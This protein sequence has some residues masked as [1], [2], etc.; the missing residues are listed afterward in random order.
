[1]DAAVLNDS[2]S[3]KALPRTVVSDS[4]ESSDEPIT[5]ESFSRFLKVFEMCKPA[6][7]ET[8]TSSVGGK[9]GDATTSKALN[10]R[11]TGSRIL[12]QNYSNDIISNDSNDSENSE[13]SSL[14]RPYSMGQETRVDPPTQKAAFSSSGS[15]IDPSKSNDS[16]SFVGAS[17]NRTLLPAE[18]ASKTAR[19][20]SRRDSGS[21]IVDSTDKYF[22]YMG[23]VKRQVVDS[24]HLTEALQAVKQEFHLQNPGYFADGDSDSSDGEYEPETD[25][26]PFAP[27]PLS[28]PKPV[29]KKKSHRHRNSHHQLIRGDLRI[30]LFKH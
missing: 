30:G 6:S 10:N 21:N 15:E 23:Q 8:G 25:S 22:V 12:Q 4:D 3:D 20:T 2:Q 19:W 24:G 5:K 26:D 17:R 7:P 14:K 1:L 9:S 11:A 13:R 18:K 29:I 27:A 28:D 16:A